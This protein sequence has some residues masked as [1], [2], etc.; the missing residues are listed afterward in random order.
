MIFEEK[1]LGTCC[2]KVKDCYGTPN[3]KFHFD[4]LLV[5]LAQGLTAGAQKI[6]PVTLNSATKINYLTCK[7]SLVYLKAKNLEK[8]ELGA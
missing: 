1:Y 7:G 4:L 2:N 6:L 8:H 5:H 3:P